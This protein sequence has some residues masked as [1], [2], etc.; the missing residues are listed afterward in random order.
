MKGINPGLLKEQ[1]QQCLQNDERAGQDTVSPKH[2]G[3]RHAVRR[4][5]R[6]REDELEQDG[7][8]S[9]TNQHFQFMT[10]YLFH[11]SK[12]NITQKG[13]Y[14]PHHSPKGQDAL[15]QAQTDNPL[16]PPLLSPMES[17]SESWTPSW[18]GDL[19]QQLAKPSGLKNLPALRRKPEKHVLGLLLARA[20]SGFHRQSFLCIVFGDPKPK[21]WGEMPHCG[22]KLTKATYPL[23]GTAMQAN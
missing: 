17:R 3:L 8:G 16:Q 23:S 19:R 5:Q 13:F 4:Q 14:T 1:H 10:E 12:K 11:L 2:Q 6:Q 15:F 22:T 21:R 18:L 7:M 20:H 9:L